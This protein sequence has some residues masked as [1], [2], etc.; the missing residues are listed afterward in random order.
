[1][2]RNCI[3]SPVL[4]FVVA[5]PGSWRG[6][7]VVVLADTEHARPEA[8]LLLRLLSRR[9]LRRRLRR[10]AARRSGLRRNP[11]LFDP[12]RR[13]LLVALEHRRDRSEEVVGRVEVA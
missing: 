9:R 6:R 3:V 7:F 1:P 12:R 8:A 13:G 11:G 2:G 4:L 5:L 10:G